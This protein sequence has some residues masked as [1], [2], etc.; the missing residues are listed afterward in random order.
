VDWGS[1]VDVEPGQVT[2]RAPND[3]YASASYKAKEGRAKPYLA[4]FDGEKWTVVPVP[5]RR[6]ALTSAAIALDGTFWVTLNDAPNAARAIDRD[7]ELWRLSSSDRRWR[8]VRLPLP[9]A[10]TGTPVDRWR[11]QP[12]DRRYRRTPAATLAYSPAEVWVGAEGDVWVSAV[13]VEGDDE[14]WTLFR[15]IPPPDRPLHFTEPIARATPA[16]AACKDT[17]FLPIGPVPA[18]VSINSDF[19]A[20]RSTLA[21]HAEIEGTEIL[22]TI[23]RGER[24]MGLFTSSV[25]AAGILPGLLKKPTLRASCAAPIATRVVRFRAE[26]GALLEE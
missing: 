24:F 10:A 4:H 18:N 9:A 21:G 13:Y 23:H 1:V 20:L 19:P 17:F 7:G 16:T 6:A 25:T 8:E 26:S 12:A 22:E 11:F 3:V 5:A 15:S 14:N 2:A